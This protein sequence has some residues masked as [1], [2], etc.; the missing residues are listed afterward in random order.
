[1]TFDFK[2]KHILVAEDNGLNLEIAVELIG[3][4]GALVDTA[5]NGQEA[6]DKFADSPLNYYDLILMDIQMPLMDGYEATEK[7]R[8]MVRADA[9]TV[10][11]F[12]MSAN[13]DAEDLKKSMRCGMNAHVSKPIELD[14]LYAQLAA[15]FNPKR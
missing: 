2:H 8:C 4:T 9:G 5:V 15:I 7:I 14:T 1:M 12:A 3:M 13:D 10:P 11:I 6:V